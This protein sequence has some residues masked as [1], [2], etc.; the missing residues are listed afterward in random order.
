MIVTGVH[1][2]LLDVQMRLKI[3]LLALWW[4]KNPVSVV[5]VI[6]SFFDLRRQHQHYRY[7]PKLMLVDGRRYSRLIIPGAPSAACRRFLKNEMHRLLPIAGYQSGL[8]VLILAITKK[9]PLQCQHCFEWKALNHKETLTLDNLKEIVKRFQNMGVAQIELS[10]GEPLNRFD[11]MLQLLQTARKNTDFWLLTSGYGLTA[12]KANRLKQAGLTGVSVSLDHWNPQWHDQFRGTEGSFNHAKEAV[13]HA[14]KANLVVALSVC[15]TKEF[16]T[17]QNLYQY[18][19]LAKDWGVHF[20][21]LLEPRAAGR[22]EGKPV[23]LSPQQIQLLEDFAQDIDTSPQ[24]LNYPLIDYYG[25]NQ[26]R[27]GCSGAG[28]RYLY[29][30]TDGNMHACPFCQ[31]SSGNALGNN[32]TAGIANLK[33]QGCHVYETVNI[34]R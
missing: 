9:C 23:H 29:I 19:E 27:A 24:Y 12:G 30:D 17:R 10:G 25:A 26:R 13:Q 2:R 18:A 7:I 31:N 22:Y 11:D 34:D 3:A 32:F 20:I 33:Q 5:K 28:N 21:R 1:K 14:L 4:Y 8:Q 15:V 6:R 16:C